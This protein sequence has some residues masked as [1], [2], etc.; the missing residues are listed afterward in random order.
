MDDLHAQQEE[1]ELRKQHLN[2]QNVGK[3]I[4]EK[5]QLNLARKRTIIAQDYN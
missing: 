4:V 3:D 2:M 5:H 1:E